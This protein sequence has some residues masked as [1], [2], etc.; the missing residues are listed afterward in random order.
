MGPLSQCNER[1]WHLHAGGA[2]RP[3]Q[4]IRQ[5]ARMSALGVQLSVLLAQRIEMGT[6]RQEVW[7]ITSADRKA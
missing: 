2:V 7:G 1:R 3:D 6:G 4:E 5:V